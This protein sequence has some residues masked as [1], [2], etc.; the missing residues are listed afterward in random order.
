M[1]VAASICISASAQLQLQTKKYRLAHFTQTSTKVVVAGDGMNDALFREGVKKA[2]NISPYEFCDIETF[3]RE[4]H[5]SSKFFLLMSQTSSYKGEDSGIMFISLFQGSRKENLY[6]V[7]SIPF[8]SASDT[9]GGEMIFLPLLL[10]ALQKDVDQIMSNEFN[11]GGMVKVRNV[12]RRWENAV[13]IAEE[14]LATTLSSSSIAAY[15]HMDINFVP[16]EQIEDYVQKMQ[17]GRLVSYVVTP[18]EGTVNGVCYTMLLDP[19]R[20]D[21]YYFNK[22]TISEK[23]GAGFL[24]SDLDRILDHRK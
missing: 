7:S 12:P 18:A 22:H 9:D 3:E 13:F 15:K 5:D 24:K 2:W 23:N 11:M 10:R 8:C 4:K 1:A 6:K 20:G 21:L 17:S 19:A 14:D 16:R